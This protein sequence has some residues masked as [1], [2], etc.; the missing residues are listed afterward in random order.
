MERLN[1][2]NLKNWQ[3]SLNQNIPDRNVTDETN[4]NKSTSIA[5]TTP[6]ADQTK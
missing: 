3:K 5:P 2:N 1:R 4:Q 6:N